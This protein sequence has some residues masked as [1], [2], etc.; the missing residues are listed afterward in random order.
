[1]AEPTIRSSS[2]SEKRDA[3]TALRDAQEAAHKR[4]EA[5]LKQ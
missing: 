3:N 5:L 2:L 4:M 1:M